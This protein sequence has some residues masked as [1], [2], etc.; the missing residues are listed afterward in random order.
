VI[1]SIVDTGDLLQVI[2]ASLA[3]GI[4]VTGV[5]GVAILGGSR[6]VDSARDGDLSAAGV[7]A[8]LGVVAFAAVV[9]S[10]VFAIVVLTEK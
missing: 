8:A 1:G 6:A 9:A 7:F 2:W 10:L 3:A 4:G 5:F